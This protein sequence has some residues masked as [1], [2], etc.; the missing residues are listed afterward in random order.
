MHV[1]DKPAFCVLGPGVPR[2][3]RAYAGGAGAY[4]HTAATSRYMD[5]LELEPLGRGQPY[6]GRLP[7][8]A[9]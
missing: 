4:E 2:L 5:D 1:K 7:L 8:P 9:R 3:Y 6:P